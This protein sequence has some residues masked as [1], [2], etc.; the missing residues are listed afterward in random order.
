MQEEHSARLGTGGRRR[1]NH[2]YCP[3]TQSAQPSG[4]PNDTRR[5]AQ[6]LC[7]FHQEGTGSIQ[8]TFLGSWNWKQKTG[9]ALFFWLYYNRNGSSNIPSPRV[10]SSNLL[11]FW[12]VNTQNTSS[13]QSYCI[14]VTMLAVSSEVV[15]REIYYCIKHSYNCK[16]WITLSK[17][18][19]SINNSDQV[20]L[21][22]LNQWILL[23]D[24]FF[25]VCGS[26]FLFQ[27]GYYLKFLL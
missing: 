7:G 6:L 13:H 23:N 18:N 22:K 21:L 2:L 16:G 27:K 10:T 25:C 17:W 4:H 11:I 12:N 20:F 19:P 1:V 26:Y 15:R 8:E 3:I 9:D 5:N 24:Y 14:P